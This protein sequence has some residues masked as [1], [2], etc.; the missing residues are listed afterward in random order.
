M[1]NR[2]LYAV[3][4]R[5]G[6]IGAVL[7]AVL[8]IGSVASAQGV[9][10]TAH[11][12]AEN[13]DIAVPIGTYSAVDPEGEG[14]EYGVSD[15]D[16][17]AISQE[18]VL[19][20]KESPDF[21]DTPSYDVNV[22][23]ND[24]VLVEVTITITN[25]EEGATVTVGPPQ[26]QV[27]RL[28]DAE[29]EDMDG[30]ETD[31][32]W[33]WQ[34]SADMTDWEEIAGADSAIY[35][36]TSAD[37]EMYLRASVSY[38]DA[39]KGEDDASTEDVDESRDTASGVSE[40][41]VEASPDANAAPMFDPGEDGV[42]HDT[43]DATPDA[44]PITIKENAEGAIG[45]P[46]TATDADNDVRLY[47]LVEV[48]PLAA[49]A[50]A[51]FEIGERS[52]QI[53]VAADTELNASTDAPVQ[54]GNNAAN[55]V[56]TITATD[57]SGA[58]GTATVQIV[59]E[60]VD[61][62]P[63]LTE[64]NATELTIGEDDSSSTT[65][66]FD[67]LDNAVDTE[68][69]DYGATD[70]DDADSTVV[71]SVSD[72]DNFAISDGGA[73]TF[74]G[75]APDYE[76]QNE[77]T[78]TITAVGNRGA[79]TADDASDDSTASSPLEVTVKVSNVDETGSVMM[80]A[81]QPQIDKSVTA[82]VEDP[83][84]DVSGVGWTWARESDAELGTDGCPAAD[85][86]ANG[87]WDVIADAE[88]ASYTPGD[89]DD[90]KCLQATA[91]YTDP[92]EAEG[93]ARLPARGVS[94]AAVEMKPA[95][96]AKPAF[97]DD[98]MPMGADPVE[99]E[100]DENTE[101]N[102]GDPI[103]ASES[104]NDLL[105][106]EL[107][108][109][110]MDSFDI[111][112]RGMGEGQISVADG[113]ELD[114]ETQTSYSLTV[115]ATDPSGASD[116][117]DVT[118]TLMPVDE[119]PKAPEGV[120]NPDEVDHAE[121]S[122]ITD[123]V[124]TYSAV[125][126]E[127]E[128]VKYGVDD[129]DNFAI[130]EDGGVLTFKES[131][132]F[133]DT[134]SY[135]V[136]VTAN[137]ADLVEVTITITN[138]EEGAT[139]TVGPPQPQAGRTAMASVE[140]MDGGEMDEM[141]TWQRSAD[142]MD[143]TDIDGAT[144]ADYTPGPDD[145]DMYLQ[146]T[147]SYVDAAKGE[148]DASTE[149]VD[150]S[151]DTASGVSERMVEASPDANAAPEFAPDVDSTPDDADD[152]PDIYR[153][154]IDE[155]STGEIG[156]AITATDADPDVR[157]YDLGPTLDAQG[158]ADNDADHMLFTINDRS[159]QISVGGDTTLDFED[160]SDEDT[161]NTYELDII[162]TDPS[163]AT[164]RATVNIV[165]E[166]VDEPPA[167]ADDAATELTIDE[168]SS[169]DDDTA[170]DEDLGP[171]GSL[172]FVATDPD[173]GS[174]VEYDLSGADEGAFDISASGVLSLKPGDDAP[175]VDYETQK[176]YKITIEAK[177]A[178]DSTAV[179]KHD[180]TVMVGNVDED[181]T[182]TMDA[183][184]PQVDKPVRASVEDP[185]GD[186]S[187]VTWQWA[188]QEVE[189]D[190]TCALAGDGGWTDIDM[191]MSASYTPG[192]DDDGDCLRATA[193][194]TDP[195]KPEDDATTDTDDESRGDAMGVTERPVEIKPVA[196][197]KPAFP[198]E[199]KPDGADPIE[200][201]V[202]EGT[203]GMILTVTADDSSDGDLLIYELGG[204]DGGSFTIVAM[205]DGEG[206]ISVGEGTTLDHEGKQ[207]YSFTAMARDPSGAYD[208]VSIT[209]NVTD[210]DEA[211]TLNNPPAFDAETAERSVDE[212]SA[213][214]TDVGDPVVAT[215]GDTGDSLTYSL[216]DMGEM[217]FAIDDM[218][219]ITVGDGAMLDHET[220]ASHTVTVTA[221]D[222]GRLT[223]T[224]MVTIMVTNENE[225]PTFD[226]LQAELMAE[227]V[228]L[229]VDENT[230][231]GKN[232]GDPVAAMDEDADDTLTY[233]LDAAGD[234]SFDIDPVTGQLMTSA[235][236]DYESGTTSYSV[237]VTATDS[238]G[239]NDAI[240]V[241]IA[242]GDMNEA[243]VFASDMAMISV[244][245][246]TAAGTEIGPPITATDE[247]EGATLEYSLGGDDAASF[248]IDAATGQLMTM[249]ALDHETKSSY[250]VTVM[251]T[252]GE[253]SAEITVM[254]TVGVDN[255]NEAPVFDEGDSAGRNVDENTEA[256]ENI[257]DP[258]T[259]TDEDAGD[260]LTY[261]LDV[262]GD[263]SFDIDSATGQLMTEAA[264]DYESGT[265]SYDV[266][267]TATDSG[268]L[269]AM[270]AVTIAVNDVPETPVFDE[271]DSADRNV[272]ENTEAG[273]NIGD[274]VTATGQDASDTLTY[275]LDEMG[276]MSFDID[277]ATGQLMT[278][279]A[280]DYES[281]TTSYDVTV[282]ATDSGGLYAMIAVTIAV[283][284][285][286][287]TPIFER[288]AAE[289]LV[290]ENV[291]VGTVVGTETAIHAESYSDDSDYFD[292][293]DMGNITTTMM[294]D[295]ESGTTSY[296]VSVTA[297]G[298]DGATDTIDV[299]VTVGDAHPG[300][301]VA[302][303]MGLTNDCEALLDAKGDLG[304]DLNWDTDTAMADWEGVTM[305]DGRVSEVWLKDE[306][307]DG[308]VSAAFGRLDML[309]VLN[310]HTNSLSGTIP[311]L[312]GASMLEELYLPN[313][314]LTGG[315]PAWL[316]GSTNLTNLWLW[317]NQLTGGIPDLSGLTNLD[318]LKLANN[319]LSGEINAAYLPQNVSW[320]IIDR[321]GFSGDIPDLSGL[322]SLELLWLH[323]NE[324]TGSVPNGTM[325]PAS[326]DDLNLRDNMLMGAIPDLSALDNL[327]RLRL[328]NN[329]LSGAVPGSLGGLD[330]LK[331]LWLHNE[332]DSEL[333]N[334]MFTSIDDGVGGLSDT[335]IEIQ[336][337]GNPWA[338]DACVPESLA[339]VD[340]NDYEAAG[341]AVCGADDGS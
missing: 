52:G 25:M 262:A 123:V 336:L 104:D 248:A 41:K 73:L 197:A 205:G 101:G 219:Q 247:D 126:P 70:S 266:T 249:A 182:V 3:L 323:T 167:F 304:G 92:V 18:G 293:D 67:V 163:G 265:T 90:G 202:E 117:V 93:D 107:G 253:H 160:E 135:T 337:G 270:I 283:N 112:E 322:T 190:G 325:L 125:D 286:P 75:T 302:G 159:G 280:L 23:A 218:G 39:A 132:D 288:E 306:G 224:I 162:A 19:S 181:G 30:G 114:Y 242:V 8:F 165:V 234:M 305:S 62:P 86:P 271:G 69:L 130:T 116:T 113:A 72:T 1:K 149:D 122:P 228:E 53:S 227:V 58:T 307:L 152:T 291:P 88:S 49:D 195:A 212:N 179:G 299:T 317:G 268:G 320:L 45:E 186:A 137:D 168:D 211:P 339:D 6:I 145:V 341:I 309:T 243:P 138:E 7:T 273:E 292:V 118:V 175:M 144:S 127:G 214:G 279:A 29:V 34:R 187:G 5:F 229:S 109:A 85:D 252:D 78:V 50:P 278:E 281:G 310:L 206:E 287:E 80:S 43:S 140:D 133:E 297:T 166:N 32:M 17:F 99:I 56:V 57:P 258:V 177:G 84:G 31:Q 91:V 275:S 257:G 296:M 232:I 129:E 254:V 97:T 96:N 300:C 128:D 298:V 222:T 263:M 142:M 199:E 209:I 180:V 255:V 315:I 66:T 261:S 13:T 35:T 143:W 156:G 225:A 338:D 196:N 161:N 184:Q 74:V 44:F 277:S 111:V 82:S 40:E 274:P 158:D 245:E 38:V 27:G 153:I 220:S 246:N 79:D 221:T 154:T 21:E 290:E 47:S 87:N 198:D 250:T 60:D 238:D 321:N 155:N 150:E 326:L 136:T 94:D 267:V 173:D 295:Y 24:A 141:W 55:Y 100:V 237:T 119:D 213:A 22:T 68:D 95:G 193:T 157:L 284:D 231:A 15:E 51:R 33:S 223:A 269:Y 61:E 301:T 314:D 178:A 81:R 9:N 103:V 131:P 48:P 172:D 185:D 318:M 210:K 328:H 59:V 65:D 200:M 217:Y 244:P 28:A 334:N 77:Y 331:Q 2:S 203:T 316:N 20:F 36:P 124:G 208:E 264:L 174:T 16:N 121:N 282:T 146:A 192:D 89:D 319:D 340:T 176:E 201:D 64:G 240:G 303:N 106:Y 272:D 63:V 226:A 14:V 235:A 313:N 215:D 312:S 251:V 76:K 233:S 327:T 236:L 83:D 188:S 12:Y 330:S 311:D 335:L 285:V 11:E 230:E 333:G 37:V 147:V 241:T 191:A 183:R 98:E 207:V 151:R 105:L 260:T 108:G 171:S 259:A 120:T 216:D 204:D 46:I 26:P 4:T 54:D 134:S 148:D 169:T 239:L 42:D 102:I 294:L 332:E 71:W 289:F 170:P 324:L 139:V 189:T 194:Y 110:D 276:D 164:G 256:G 329:S 10:S 308:S 115:T